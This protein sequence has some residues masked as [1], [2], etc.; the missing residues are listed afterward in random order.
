MRVNDPP[1]TVMDVIEMDKSAM[2]TEEIR[3]L[4]L[5]ALKSIRKGMDRALKEISEIFQEEYEAAEKEI[6]DPKVVP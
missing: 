3:V 1:K 2:N 5:R 4:Q 6:L